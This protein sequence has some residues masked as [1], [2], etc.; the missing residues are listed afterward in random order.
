MKSSHLENWNRLV[1]LAR[2]APVDVHGAIELPPGFATR[3]VALAFSP[4]ERTVAGLF[5]PF[6]FR[7][8]SIASLVAIAAVALNVRPVLQ[9]IR[10]DIVIV[11]TDP[12]LELVE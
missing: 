12:V 5:E 4:S 9:S 1:A 7:A 8:L 6:A 10:D 3:V 11:G 2:Q